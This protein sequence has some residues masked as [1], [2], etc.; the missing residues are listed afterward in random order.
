MKN[1][2]VE[3]KLWRL[4]LTTPEVQAIVKGLHS[5]EEVPAEIINQIILK[6]GFEGAA[7]KSSANIH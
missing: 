3:E 7:P 5:V 6:I 2:E 4:N 1:Q